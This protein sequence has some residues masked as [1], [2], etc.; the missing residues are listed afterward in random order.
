MKINKEYLK[1]QYLKENQIDLTTVKTDLKKIKKVIKSNVFTC[2]P[3]RYQLF[4]N[5]KTG[6]LYLT[7][8]TINFDIVILGYSDKKIL[9]DQMR[10]LFPEYIFFLKKELLVDLIYFLEINQQFMVFLMKVIL[11]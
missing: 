8:C 6:R 11:F 2:Y 3:N 9:N 5:K 7:V 10:E 4:K 1:Q